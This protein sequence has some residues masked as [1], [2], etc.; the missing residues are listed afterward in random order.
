MSEGGML[1]KW[2]YPPCRE[3]EKWYEWKG[4]YKVWWSVNLNA[5]ESNEILNK[6][7]D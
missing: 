5:E 3:G 7:Y 4:F 6:T 1:W 2:D